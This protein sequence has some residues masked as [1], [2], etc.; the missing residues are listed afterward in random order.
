MN[1]IGKSKKKLHYFDPGYILWKEKK[2]IRLFYFLIL[3]TLYKTQIYIALFPNY[4][5]ENENKK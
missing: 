4:N 5:L 2:S 1:Y 3:V